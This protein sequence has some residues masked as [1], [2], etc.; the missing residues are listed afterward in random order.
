MKP[1]KGKVSISLDASILQDIKMYSQSK[2]VSRSQVI[3][4]ILKMWQA[5]FK[6]REMIEGYKAMN[7]EN[8]RIA[9]EFSSLAQ[10]VC[11]DE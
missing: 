6:K 9:E 3:E 4:S 1:T 8:T 7:Q 5:E 10:E 2:K 11:P